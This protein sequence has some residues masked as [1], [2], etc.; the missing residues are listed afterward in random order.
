MSLKH[1][2]SLKIKRKN[3]SLKKNNIIQSL[4]KGIFIFA[5]LLLGAC[6]DD[7][8]NYGLDKYY[9][10]IA[11]T[12]N[13]GTFLLDNGKT[14]YSIE[15]GNFPDLESGQRVYLR[16]SYLEDDSNQITI[17]SCSKISQ[18]VL[19]AIPSQEISALANDLIR[20]ES[21][22]IGSHFLN[23]QFYMEYKSET[24]QITLAIDETNVN[25]EEVN[26]YF[27]HDKKEDAPG[28]PVLVLVSYDLSEVLGEPKGDRKLSINFNTSNYG[29][30]NFQY[31]Y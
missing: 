26:L 30:R 12:L 16:F 14:V 28:Y 2:S 13:P 6:E 23:I 10:E 5:L 19:T 7:S 11:T 29:D 1:I 24:H 4:A 20:F 31:I 25:D 15:N 27:R 18:G 3:M 17:H 22:W 21:A 8:V 9:T